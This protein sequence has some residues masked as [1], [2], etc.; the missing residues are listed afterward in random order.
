[1]QFSFYAI[2]KP[3]KILTL[4]WNYKNLSY[5]IMSVWSTSKL[6]DFALNFKS[7]YTQ[8]TKIDNSVQKL[9]GKKL[10]S[11]SCSKNDWSCSFH[12]WPKQNNGYDKIRL[13]PITEADCWIF[14]NIYSPPVLFAGLFNSIKR[15]KHFWKTI[16][17]F[18]LRNLNL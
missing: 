9:I 5:D 1:M 14:K 12:N 2:N 15:L 10:C 17:K 7:L 13:W 18:E 8:W 4:K 3:G 16:W 11:M 6:A